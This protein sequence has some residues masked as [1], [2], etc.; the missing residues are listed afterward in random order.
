MKNLLLR[1]RPH[2][3][4]LLLLAVALTAADVLLRRSGWSTTPLTTGGAGLLGKALADFVAGAAWESAAGVFAAWG[5]YF[6]CW[7]LGKNR[8]VAVAA[9]I[10]FGAH[11]W[12][13]TGGALGRGAWGFLAWA[14]A[15]QAR[16]RV[17]SARFPNRR[18]PAF[19]PLALGAFL[20]A[21]LL[22]KGVWPFG[23]LLPLFDLALRRE[24][25]RPPGVDLV[26]HTPWLLVALVAGIAE[27]A[28]GDAPWAG[29]GMPAWMFL[30]QWFHPSLT[31]SGWLWLAL[32]GALAALLLFLGDLAFGWG[33]RRTLVRWCGAGGVWLLASSALAA[34][35]PPPWR[36][37]ATGVAWSLPAMALSVALWR[38]VVACVP[39]F[40][41]ERPPW[42]LASR[43]LGLDQLAAA[44]IGPAPSLAP[45]PD[46]P[47]EELP[48]PFSPA[49]ERALEVV[50]RP[51]ESHVSSP[52]VAGPP[53]L[54][55]GFLSDRML[56]LLAPGSIWA[57][58]AAA[59]AERLWL[60]RPTSESRGEWLRLEGVSEGTLA[61][62]DGWNLAEEELESVLLLDAWDTLDDALRR[63]LLEAADGALTDT[64]RVL[65]W[66]SDVD[67][68]REELRPAAGLRLVEET[69]WSGG[70]FVTLA[71][72]AS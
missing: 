61:D 28:V 32:P 51:E 62:F 23:L 69:S 4:A 24:P 34:F 27:G 6:A 64:G 43:G 15:V 5:L 13:L 45:I 59:R 44:R 29:Q 18:P 60:L 2:G 48:P 21:V 35:V 40:A 30:T 39:D 26:G 20:G 65:V 67:R 71:R 16:P 54:V 19:H 17:R 46:P 47:A 12:I 36:S 68:L 14:L 57:G 31:S 22:V 63:R 1:L 7:R 9:A 3:P 11:P 52:W 66:T 41:P 50:A 33:D 56:A 38:L 53:G 25:G 72:R 49:L 70:L 42:N 8:P 37:V 58:R 55:E 10:L